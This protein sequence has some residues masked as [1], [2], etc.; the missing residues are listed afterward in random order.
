NEGSCAIQVFWQPGDPVTMVRYYPGEAPA[1]DVYAGN[2]VESIPMPPAAGCTT[3]VEIELTDREDAFMVKGHHNQLFT[4]DYAR[5]FRLFAQLYKM[6]LA[7][8]G[9]KGIWPA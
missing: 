7:D 5:K 3:N 9:F 4:G 1:L 6:R 8:T 2:V